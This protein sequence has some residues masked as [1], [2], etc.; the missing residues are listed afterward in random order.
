MGINRSK[1]GC[2]MGQT[3]NSFVTVSVF[4]LAYK[5]FTCLSPLT[6]VTRQTCKYVYKVIIKVLYSTFVQKHSDFIGIICVC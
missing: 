4:L 5:H 2:V 1:C 3:C 6:V